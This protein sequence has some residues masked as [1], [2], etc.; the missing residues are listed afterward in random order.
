MREFFIRMIGVD[1]R[2]R[3]MKKRDIPQVQE[4]AKVSWYATYTGIIPVRIQKN[5]LK[6][7]YSKKTMKR[8]L[9]QTI[10]YVAEVDGEIVGFANYSPVT[11]EGKTELGALYLHPDY[12]GKGIGTAFLRQ[13]IEELGA[14]EI[15][16]TVEK[17]NKI[18]R[19]FYAAKGFELVNEYEDMLEDHVLQTMQLVL[20]VKEGMKI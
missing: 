7:A 13:G 8:R 17:N 4:I 19:A 20:K 12:Q 5:F 2:I 9:K 1:Y 3:K 10:V 15:H 11:E 14:R 18:G 6:I 16:L